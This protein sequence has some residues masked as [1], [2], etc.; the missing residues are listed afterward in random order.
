MSLEGLAI[1]S[2]ENYKKFYDYLAKNCSRF[3]P[4]NGDNCGVL[5]ELEEIIYMLLLLILSEDEESDPE[6]KAG[7]SMLYD[8]LRVLVQL[9]NNVLNSIDVKD[10]ETSKLL[11]N[12]EVHKL[13]A[14]HRHDQPHPSTKPSS[15]SPSLPLA[16]SVGTPLDQSSEFYGSIDMGMG[17]NGEY[18]ELSAFGPTPVNRQE[19]DLFRDIDRLIGTNTTLDVPA[20]VPFQD[21]KDNGEGTDTSTAS[22]E[23][24]LD[25]R[26]SDLPL[27][28][29]MLRHDADFDYMVPQQ[30]QESMLQDSSSM[31]VGPSNDKFDPSHH[32][33]AY[34]L[35]G[36]S[37]E[38][39]STTEN[40]VQQ[41]D[42]IM[43]ND[44][45]L[46]IYDQFFT[47]PEHNTIN[48]EASSEDHSLSQN[49]S[50]H[51]NDHPLSST[52]DLSLESQPHSSVLD[53]K[54]FGLVTQG[55]HYQHQ[56]Q[57]PAS[58]SADLESTSPAPQSSGNGNTLFHNFM[59]DFNRGGSH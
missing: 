11:Q 46:H 13:L 53:F 42:A 57:V 31:G 4:K 49:W 54:D 7:I 9:Y 19:S 58:S 25:A 20:S 44:F 36:S 48:F 35:T 59:L 21:S 1:K 51:Q 45:S 5:K 52:Q 6:N 40:R 43:G 24:Q 8:T 16:P 22:Y 32:P 15:H 12:P 34:P 56:N 38:T 10:R 2:T 41:S 17:I 33:Q 29:T 39:A 55:Y 14:L 28:Q 37:Q 3:T 18:P 47:T 23:H 50:Q 26:L 30:A 27:S